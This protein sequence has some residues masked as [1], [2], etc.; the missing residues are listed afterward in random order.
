MKIN[1]AILEFVADMHIKLTDEQKIKLFQLLYQGIHW[2]IA[3]PTDRRHRPPASDSD[4][5]NE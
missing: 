1:K 5:A 2:Y 4:L 3:L